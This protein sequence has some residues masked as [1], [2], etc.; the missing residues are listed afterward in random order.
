[1]AEIELRH[2]KYLLAIAET[3][4]FTRAAERLGIQ[5]PPLTRQIRDLEARVGAQ[6]VERLS[7]GARLTEAGEAVAATARAMLD[8]AADLPAI[9]ARAA[10][11]QS[12]RLR[13]G[14][15]SSAA[16]HPFLLGAIRVFR[17]AAPGVRLSLEEESSAE[18][19]RDL[20]AD[21]LDAAVLRA[22]AAETELEVDFL[23]EEPMAAALPAGHRLAGQAQAGVALADLAGET[24]VLYR[25]PAGAGLYDAVI[26]ACHAAGFSPAVGQEAPRMPSTLS[27]VAAGLGVS[28]VPASMR[29]MAVEGVVLAP[30]IG[31]HR[32]AAPLLLATRHDRSAVAARFRADL[33]RA[34][35]AW[36]G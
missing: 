2:L 8:Q 5:Q 25:R 7:R 35:A 9:A 18:L 36:E 27:L 26:A 28:V 20:L 23:L 22:P 6:L 15:T 24:F 34:A 12:G 30:L 4:G 29:R 32:P 10:A 3:G 13:V 1:M 17:G 31:P 16:F 21:R 11:G 14:Y 19:V 33:R